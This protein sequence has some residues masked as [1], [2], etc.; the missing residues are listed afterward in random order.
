MKYGDEL[1]EIFRPMLKPEGHNQPYKWHNPEGAK[2][3]TRN[4]FKTPLRMKFINQLPQLVFEPF[5]F[6]LKLV[7]FLVRS[8]F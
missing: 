6:T 7:D 4:R 1:S 5:Y 8:G 2:P 3:F